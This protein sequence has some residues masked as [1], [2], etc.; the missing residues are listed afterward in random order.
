MALVQL[1]L[2]VPESV[3]AHWREQA[4]EAGHAS[5]RDWLVALTMPTATPPLPPALEARLTALEAAVSQL[6]ATPTRVTRS[7]PD[8][9]APP[10]W[11]GDPISPDGAI[12][13]AVLAEQVLG[14][15]RHTLNARL[16]RLGGAR[17]GLE[18]SDGW[19]CVGKVA[20]PQ[21]GPKQWCWVQ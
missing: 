15:R 3:A 20:P 14:I 17:E 21:G 9:V 2:K 1:N 12:T 4:K 8:R 5:V 16:A 19:R 6:Q 10:V 13:T 18:L 7:T 11:T